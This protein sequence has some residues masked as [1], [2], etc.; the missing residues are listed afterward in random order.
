MKPFDYQ[1]YLKNNPLLKESI[2]EGSL[3]SLI[4]PLT[5][6]LESMGYEVDSDPTPGFQ[7]LEAFKKYP[8]GSVL[9]MYLS[10]SDKEISQSMSSFDDYSTIDVSFTYWTTQVTKKFFGLFKSKQRVVQDLPDETGTNIDLGTGMFDIPVE[11]S[12]NRVISLL[13][14]AEQKI[15]GGTPTRQMSGDADADF[16]GEAVSTDF[17]K[18]AL[19]LVT[20]AKNLISR[21]GESLVMNS[22]VKKAS[23]ITDEDGLS[24]LYYHLQ[25]VL[26][27]L[28][29]SEARAFTREAKKIIVN[30]YGITMTDEYGSPMK[31]R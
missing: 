27:E 23:M 12:V 3:K 9:R 26:G 13:K 15:S 17:A 30:K 22:E 1:K 6:K 28:I 20:L 21:A 10:P 5:A 11:D 8:D 25:D 14:K 24:K 19:E 7:T 31:W 29:G 18:A 2:N 4:A 16:M